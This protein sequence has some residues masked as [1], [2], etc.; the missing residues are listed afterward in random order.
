MVLSKAFEEGTM[1]LAHLINRAVIS[2]SGEDA[3]NFLGGLVTCAVDAG[4]PARYGALLTPQG[5]IIAD[6]FL[7][8][9]GDGKGGFL[10][11]APK[12]VAEG[13]LKRLSI[14][15]L[16][17][18]VALADVSGE[19]SVFA[20][21]GEAS[22]RAEGRHFRDP[23][24]SAM[25]NRFIAA[26]AS[27]IASDAA[28]AS[29]YDAHRISLA[30]PEGGRDFAFG[31]AFPHEACMDELN[32]VDFDK[33]CYVGQEVV[34]RTQHRGTART[35]VVALS[36]S[37]AP[38]PEGADIK[39][40]ERR[41]G[42]VGSIDAPGRRGIATVRLDHLGDAFSARQPL[43]CGEAEVFARK[44]PWANYHFPEHAEQAGR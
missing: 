30:I 43:M 26:S 2:V 6:F 36:F 27:L 14:Y 29:T 35:R 41:L 18:K 11:D 44:P 16:R 40:G 25:G 32:G 1:P 37:G 9:A 4:G 19:F 13:L 5:K 39:A 23:R 22:A 31:D 7:I 21:W 10:I 28:S 3:A 33:G 15:K 17:A 8:P 42:R 34:S 24:F 12:S 20:R 38:P